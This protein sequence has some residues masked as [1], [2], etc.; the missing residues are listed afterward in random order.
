MAFSLQSATNALGSLFGK[1]STN[2]AVGVDIGSSSIKAVQLRLDKE[3]A[4]LETYGEIALAPY[5]NKPVGKA[6]RLS[7]EQTGDAL[8]DLIQEANITATDAGAAIPF[9]SS[10]VS[11]IDM[12]K[13]PPEQLRRM[14]PIEARKYI[15][16][17]S[18]EI[19]LDWF[20]IPPEEE[21]SAFD[22]VEE[23][24]VMQKRG[25][26]VLLAAI[27]NDTLRTHQAILAS[28]NLSVGFFEIEVFSA[29]RSSLD[30]GIAPIIVVDIGA[31]TTKIY[32]VE[33]GIVR[34][35]HLVNS[36][37]QTITETLARTLG[38]SFEKAERMKREWGFTMASAYS[39]EENE[40]MHTALL[41]TLDRLFNEVNRVLLSY[42]RRYNKNVS[43]VVLTGG[44]S[45]LPGLV[46]KAREQLNID[47]AIAHPFGK[48]AAPAF[49]DEVLREIG[50]GFS[51]ALGA[52]LRR[53]R[54]KQ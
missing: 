16:V 20:I 31:A 14:I 24:T 2:S 26:E 47:V 25:Q 23:K 41:S 54:Q 43:H 45:A 50:P 30:R 33:R 8:K 46:E 37:S 38:W 39:R 35:S 29:I 10:L 32:V 4:V 1:R 22:R 15:P 19:M 9:S 34:T 44:G 52:A 3:T 13:V 49:L 53:L 6:V 18:S 42:G 27:H 28:A 17:S 40:K 36:G 11:I 12:P 5:D 7:P 51:V 48:V 21:D